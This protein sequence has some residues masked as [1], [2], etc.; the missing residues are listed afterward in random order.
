MAVS[1]PSRGP[2]LERAHP[3]DVVP[4]QTIPEDS[5][6]EILLRDGTW[7]WCRVM[8]QRKDRLGR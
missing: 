1:D 7:A 3:A 6:A 5:Q 2:M 4:G 8:G